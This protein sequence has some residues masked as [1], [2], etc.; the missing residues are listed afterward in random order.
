[1][2]HGMS[3]TQTPVNKYYTNEV[4]EGKKMVGKQQK[5][6]TVPVPQGN[7]DINTFSNT[8]SILFNHETT[9]NMEKLG[10]DTRL[11]RSEPG[12]GKQLIE[13]KVNAAVFRVNMEW[14]YA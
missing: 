6:I 14:T 7:E 5:R 9:I 8:V 3:G 2:S 11:L 4:E 10:H 13:E 12:K 1:M